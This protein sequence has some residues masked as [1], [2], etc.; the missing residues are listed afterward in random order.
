M[1]ILGETLM[2]TVE[3]LIQSISVIEQAQSD[4][5]GV[6]LKRNN[7]IVKD[8]LSKLWKLINIIRS[9]LHNEHAQVVIAAAANSEGEDSD[10]PVIEEMP[11]IEI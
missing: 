7:S 8:T 10:E 6:M 2:G 9:Q 11:A 5:Y 4:K 1:S 3:D